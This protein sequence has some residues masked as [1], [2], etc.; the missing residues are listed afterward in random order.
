MFILLRYAM[1][2]FINMFG[3]SQ[4]AQ[5]FKTSTC[6]GADTF[7]MKNKKKYFFLSH[8]HMLAFTPTTDEK[9][10]W[11]STCLVWTP[12][13]RKQKKM[14]C[15]HQHMLAPHLPQ[16]KKKLDADMF[17][18][19]TSNMK[20]KKKCFACTNMLAPHLPQMKKKVGR[21]HVWCGPLN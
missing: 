2:L 10:S 3:W 6:F 18:V 21:R 13:T 5:C 8:Q 17:G 15:M 11:T 4:Q 1:L 16:M 9:K 7:N 14:F 20:T 19:D 12:P